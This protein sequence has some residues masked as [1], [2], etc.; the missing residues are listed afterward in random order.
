MDFSCVLNG[1][2]DCFHEISKEVVEDLNHGLNLEPVSKAA[3]KVQQEVL[4]KVGEGY[5]ERSGRRFSKSASSIGLPSLCLRLKRM[6]DGKS[7]VTICTSLQLT[8]LPSVSRNKY[9]YD[10]VIRYA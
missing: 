8:Q 7:F 6:Q 9:Y 3:E 2:N 5:D 4:S 10:R 1:R